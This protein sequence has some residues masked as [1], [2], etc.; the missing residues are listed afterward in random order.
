MNLKNK[1]LTL[2]SAGGVVYKKEKNKIKWLIVKPAGRKEWRLP[3]GLIEKNETSVK[4]AM[5]EVEEEGGV[6]AVI[7]EKVGEIKYFYTQD[8]QKVLKTVIFFLMEYIEGDTSNHDEEVEK[9]AFLP[10]DK[11]YNKLTYE[12]EKEILAQAYE[13]LKGL[14]KEE[15]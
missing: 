11:A 6:K 4:A 8:G 14:E 5:R 13:I 7:K 15:E 10:F 9:V 1:I 2:K 3:K 12:T